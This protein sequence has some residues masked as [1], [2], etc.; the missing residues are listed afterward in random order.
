MQLKPSTGGEVFSIEIAP[1]TKVKALKQKIA[2]KFQITVSE[3]KLIGKGKVL[4]D[5][6]PFSDFGLAA[7]NVVNLVLPVT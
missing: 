7:T 6:L 4:K 1:S 3:V 2:D 5:H